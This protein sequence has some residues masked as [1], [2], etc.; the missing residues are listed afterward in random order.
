M[1]WRGIRLFLLVSLGAQ[2]DGLVDSTLDPA[3]CLQCK[4]EVALCSGQQHRDSSGV[5]TSKLVPGTQLHVAAPPGHVV[6]DQGGHVSSG[7][8]PI[9]LRGAALCRMDVVGWA[10]V[11]EAPLQHSP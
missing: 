3:L 9:P 4:T 5:S 1:K 7:P 8:Q 10:G 11:W 6:L 2:C